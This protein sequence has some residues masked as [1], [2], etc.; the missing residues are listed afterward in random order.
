MRCGAQTS[1]AR[2]SKTQRLEERQQDLEGE[3]RRLMAKP[4]AS[5]TLSQGPVRPLLSGIILCPQEASSVLSWLSPA[6]SFSSPTSWL[7][8]FSQVT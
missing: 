3:L 7:C 6:L 2:R 8:I 5:V 4:G 1:C